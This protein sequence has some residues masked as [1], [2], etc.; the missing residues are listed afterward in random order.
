MEGITRDPGGGHGRGSARPTDKFDVV[1]FGAGIA[2]LTVAHELMARDYAVLVIDPA[3]GDNALEGVA[4][5]GVAKTQAAYVFRD[6]L[7][8]A[9]G[10][11]IRATRGEVPK[12][13]TVQY[14]DPPSEEPRE[15]EYEKAVEHLIKF[16]EHAKRIRDQHKK[17]LEDSGR[18]ELSALVSLPPI[19]VTSY[20]NNLDVAKKRA[21]ALVNRLGNDRELGSFTSSCPGLFGQH[22][23]QVNRPGQW[24]N[25]VRFLGVFE[26]PGEHGF[27]FF[28]SFYHNLFDT[29][30]R[31][32][33]LTGA[34]L[35]SK[36]PDE[37]GHT[38]FD[39]LCA[40][41]SLLVSL[42][43]KDKTFTVPRRLPRSLQALRETIRRFYGSLGFSPQDMLRMESKLI[44]YGTS[45]T[46]RREAEYEKQ[47]WFEFVDGDSYS[48]KTQKYLESSSQALGALRAKDSDA[49]T[50]GNTVIQLMYDQMTQG[51]HSDAILAG[52]TT[53]AWF[54][55]WQLF[56]HQEGVRFACGALD[57]FKR[58]PDKSIQP[59][60]K[61]GLNLDPEKDREA[62]S[63]ACD[64][65]K[66]LEGRISQNAY[67][68]IALG[69]KEVAEL[70]AKYEAQIGALPRPF[71]QVREFLGNDWKEDLGVAKPRGPLKHLSGI[72]FFF[73]E[74]LHLIDGHILY[75]DA[76]W[77]LTSISQS[78]KWFTSRGRNDGFRSVLSVDI[79][80]WGTKDK[81]NGKVA[82]D[83][84]R[85][86]I[87]MKVWEQISGTLEERVG[88]PNGGSLP[89]PAYYHI[90]DNIVFKSE[91]EGAT[92]VLDL[93]PFLVNYKGDYQKRPG[94][95]GAYSLFNDQWILAGNYVQTYTRLTT[96]EAPNESGRHAVNAILKADRY[97]GDL[98]PIVD[99]ESESEP[100]DLIWF[101]NLD[102]YLFDQGARH[103]LDIPGG[104]HLL[105]KLL[106]SSRSDI[107]A[108]L[109]W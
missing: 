60:Y 47:S 35:G 2:G 23:V 81:P 53:E 28:P 62:W 27:R 17:H 79:G 36:S 104:I 20:S 12:L 25:C 42:E 48:P 90:D 38:V 64:K 61:W 101:K 63:T 30:K 39:N 65:G 56:L 80:D 46:K 1:V 92:P 96:M 95:P 103:F 73:R 58:D 41:E 5:G 105:M 88:I 22:R 98:V 70:T 21:E 99:L 8:D 97:S 67:F 44:K 18:K 31:T 57:G 32:P 83:C 26:L 108:L 9:P 102:E 86:E 52:P 6:W 49:R 85:Q 76:P 7:P 43:G 72:Q 15:G 55:H 75:P 74:E 68:V 34:G 11:M 13:H 87:A 71:E 107:S 69:V 59:R 91:D 29:M 3:Q 50:Y 106:P 94:K 51:K 10:P 77:G 37:P 84:T 19:D 66:T 4:V 16:C 24:S 40:T 93:S 82:W 54:Q 89:A 45:C 33:L 14:D 78:A 100:K 109:N